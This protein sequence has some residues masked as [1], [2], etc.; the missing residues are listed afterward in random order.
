M[1]ANSQKRL[2]FTFYLKRF[3]LLALYIEYI[4]YDVLEKDLKM[5]VEDIRLHAVH[6]AGKPQKKWRYSSSSSPDHCKIRCEGR[7]GRSI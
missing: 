3:N 5:S 2:V 4:I 7:Q 1:M 6:R